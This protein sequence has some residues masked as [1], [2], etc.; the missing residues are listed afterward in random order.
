MKRILVISL[1]LAFSLPAFGQVK[2]QFNDTPRPE[3]DVIIVN[4][5]LQATGTEMWLVG[6]VFNRGLKP[7]HNVRVTPNLTSKYGT[8]PPASTLYIATSDIPPTSFADFE[9]RVALYSDLEISA[10]PTVEWDP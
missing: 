3:A 5:V 9:G 4:H 6:R 2:Y 1:F 10:R 7:A 8:R